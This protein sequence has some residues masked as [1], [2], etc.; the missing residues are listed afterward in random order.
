MKINT[1]YHSIGERRKERAGD[2]PIKKY[3]KDA[4]HH[5]FLLEREYVRALNATKM[6]RLFAKPFIT[7]IC[8]DSEGITHLVKDSESPFFA[9][10]SYD[11][12]VALWDMKTRAKISS[13]RYDAPIAAIALD[14][15]QNIYASQ[16][17]SIFGR[18]TE[19]RAGSIV[20]GLDFSSF[21]SGTGD[22]S[23]AAA[24][25]IQ[26]FDVSRHTPKITYDV[27]DSLAVSFNSSFRHLMAGITALGIDMYDNRACRPVAT[28]AA[29]GASCMEFNPQQ[30][31]VL[32]V[33][34]EDGN[35]YSYDIR[36]LDKPLGTYRG[37]VNAVVSIAFNPNGKELATGSYDKSIRIFNF[38]DRKARDC[39]Y[40]DR[41]HLVH[42]L[43]YS[44]DGRFIVSGSDDGSLRLWK[45]R[46]SQKTTPV[47]RR[48]REAGEYRDALKNKFK[49]VAS[50][51]RI[52]KHRHLPKELK[53]AG[54]ERHEMHEAKLRRDARMAERDKDE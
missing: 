54:K 45:A 11:N 27:R 37:H 44:N 21:S 5:P 52:A 18:G 17:K 14:Q 29:T 46:A 39:Y 38:Q 32:G 48:E 3:S 41:M 6:E 50:I 23:V 2:A 47:S 8:A 30:G 34:N 36:Q 26:I 33:G 12:Q 19:Y 40:N 31:Y 4:V 35:A 1:I 24:D 7:A 25:N 16:A 20:R 13:T 51:E 22:I 9:T 10:A 49:G 43:V 28:L 15:D 42:G 53:Q